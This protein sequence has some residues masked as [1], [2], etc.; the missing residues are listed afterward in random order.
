MIIFEIIFFL[1]ILTITSISLAGYGKIITYRYKNSFLENILFGYIFIAFLITAIHFVTNINI[2]IN[3][4]V[5]LIGLFFFIKNSNFIFKNFFFTYL[6][7]IISLIPIFLTQKYH[8]DFGYYHLPY[9]LTMMDQ[10]IIFGLANSNI[11]YT[12]NSIWL[13]IITIFSFTK[14]NYNFLTLPSFLIYLVFIIF[15]LK[16]ILNSPIRKISTYFLIVCLFYIILKF[17]R[18]SEYGND[19]PATLFSILTIFYF[20]KFSEK[21]E[22][23]KTFFNFFCCFSFAVFSILIKFS[24]IPIFLLPLFLF[25]KNFNKLK[26]ELIKP[27][28]L[29]IFLLSILFFLQQFIYTGCFFFPSKLTCFDVSWFNNDFLLVRENLE[30]INKSY[31]SSGNVISKKDYLINFNWFPFWFKRN[32]PEIL[33]HLI[34]M[35]LPIL[36]FIIFSKKCSEK[37][38]LSFENKHVF[39]LF[40]IIG[41]IFWLKFSP[42][43][44]FAIPYFLSLLFFISFKYFMKKNFSKNFFLVLIIFSLFF[45][46]SKNI[47]R[48]SSEADIFF[49]IKK[50]D[51]KYFVDDLSKNKFVSVHR[52]DDKNNKNG[53]QGRLCWD[54]PFICSYNK[55]TV[56]KKYGYLFFSKLNN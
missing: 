34:T 15:S 38:K 3:L 29:L 46:F 7:L 12:H 41:F 40:I 53:W 17:T 51:N 44:R 52:P 16:I 47:L 42:V 37:F 35:S 28:Y 24:S 6:L 36:L 30:I 56:N 21:N 55:M 18:L 13:N 5:I 31:S 50:I 33:E 27:N 2:Y 32:Y 23:N 4:T 43:Y 20:L 22:L 49:G 54:I 14:D 8:E 26:K 25:A 19:L 45:N 48:I 1:I 9:V 39:I 10:K 11:A